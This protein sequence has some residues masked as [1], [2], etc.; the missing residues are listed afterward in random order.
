MKNKNWDVPIPQQPF[1]I[2]Q[3]SITIVKVYRNVPAVSIENAWSTDAET[4][5]FTNLQPFF[6]SPYG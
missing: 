6:G 5:A 1:T 2:Q 4:Y 3:L